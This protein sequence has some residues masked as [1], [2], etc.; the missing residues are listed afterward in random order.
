MREGKQEVGKANRPQ[1]PAGILASDFHS[2]LGQL[3]KRGSLL[4]EHC[5]GA[6]IYHLLLLVVH[7]PLPLCQAARTPT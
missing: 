5:S 2:S 7:L 6:V 3:G 1:D 4:P